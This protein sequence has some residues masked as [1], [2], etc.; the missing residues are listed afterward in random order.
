MKKLTLAVIAICS[1]LSLFSQ[2][3]SSNWISYPTGSGAVASY[4]YAT[5]YDINGNSYLLG[6]YNNQNGTLDLDPG[7]GSQLLTGFLGMFV[8]KTDP[9]GTM[10]WSTQINCTQNSQYGSVSPRKIAC[11]MNGDVYITGGITDLTIDFDDASAVNPILTTAG[12]TTGD[13]FLAK[14]DSNNGAVLWS[15]VL[16]STANEEGRDIAFDGNALYFVGLYGCNTDFDPS[17]GTHIPP[18]SANCVSGFVAKYDLD[19]NFGWEVSLCGPSLSNAGYAA[20][21]SAKVDSQHNICFGGYMNGVVEF[22]PATA[23]WDTMSATTDGFFAKYDSSGTFLWAKRLSTE[24]YITQPYMTLDDN[25][26]IILA[27]YFNGI[28]DYDMGPGTVMDTVSSFNMATDIFVAKY[29]ANGNYLW[30]GSIGNW[31]YNGINDLATDSMGNIYIT[32]SFSD[33][34]DIDLGPGVFMLTDPNNGN[35][36]TDGYLLKYTPAGNLYYGFQIST[37][38]YDHVMGI[39]VRND[40]VLICGTATDVFDYDPTAATMNSAP[41]GSPSYFLAQYND[42]AALIGISPIHANTQNNWFVYPNPA[43]DFIRIANM[44]GYYQYQLINN[45]GQIVFSGKTNNEIPVAD[46]NS[47]VY[48]LVLTNENGEQTTFR[49]V[50]E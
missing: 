47:G 18:I 21:L 39:D 31:A 25:D 9:N 34:I 2:L 40:Q 10:L 50:R 36:L 30:S 42:T 24:L 37:F 20:P 7:S 13:M 23:L 15:H 43:S 32:G 45:L 27:G 46:L 33:P 12:S 38:G 11:D 8:T 22:D 16:G 4:V 26:N 6:A 17:S 14:Y 44:T 35:G 28:I 49:F 48:F 3:P 19:G 1:C 41:A 29:D 5:S